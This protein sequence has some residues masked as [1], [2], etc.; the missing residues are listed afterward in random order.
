MASKPRP[1]GKDQLSPLKVRGEGEPLPFA[2]MLMRVGQYSILRVSQIS[3]V[4]D[5]RQDR[6]LRIKAV[7]VDHEAAGQLLRLQ[8]ERAHCGVIDFELPGNS[9]QSSRVGTRGTGPLEHGGPL[10]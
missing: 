4:C 3:L 8:Q 10:P 5:D 6:P 1:R 7:G 2:S 9:A